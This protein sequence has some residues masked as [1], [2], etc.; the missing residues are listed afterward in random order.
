[1]EISRVNHNGVNENMDAINKMSHQH[2]AQKT[3][4]NSYN[5]PDSGDTVEISDEGMEK[6]ASMRAGKSAEDS[7][8]GGSQ[9]GVHLSSGQGKSVEELETKLQDKKSETKRKQKKLEAAER[10][11]EGDSSMSDEVSKLENDVRKLKREEKQL[12]SK[13]YSS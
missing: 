13:V 4:D 7:G 3:S 10:K 6:S 9:G 11:A 5:V 8:D 12:K 2:N 1:M